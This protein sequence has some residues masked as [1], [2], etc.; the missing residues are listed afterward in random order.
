MDSEKN[1][2]E[3]EIYK[4]LEI[5]S[6]LSLEGNTDKAQDI[7]EQLC[8]KGSTDAKIQLGYL[9]LKAKKTS[10]DVARAEQLFREAAVSGSSL[11]R[12]YLGL[13][14]QDIGR[15]TEA[16]REIHM[17]AETG[18]LPAVNRLGWYYEDGVGCERSLIA[19]THYREHA[20]IH[21]H[22]GAQ[23][24][25]AE[26]MALGRRGLLSVPSGIVRYFKA[27]AQIFWHT[28]KHPNDPRVQG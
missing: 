21:G 23:R 25:I 14:Y 27:V 18:Y 1:M 8:Q 4:E 24:W 15:D 11:G 17:L 9:L 16:F 2:D 12:Y 13:L 5:A 26:Q 3:S 28:L 10:T 6:N 19:A 20:A 7:Y 22:F